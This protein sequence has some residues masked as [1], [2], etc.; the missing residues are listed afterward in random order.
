MDYDENDL[1]SDDDHQLLQQMEAERLLELI[2]GQITAEI[3]AS[4]PLEELDL[5]ED[6][7]P[8]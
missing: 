6:D 5:D 7:Y 4:G 2:Q 8:F 1:D 3:A